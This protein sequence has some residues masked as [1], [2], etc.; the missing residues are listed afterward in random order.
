M[1]IIKCVKKQS[2]FFRSRAHVGGRDA[3]GVHRRVC[4]DRGG[5]RDT[6]GRVRHR[7]PPGPG[8]R[9]LRRVRVQTPD[10]SRD[11]PNLKCQ[12]NPVRHPPSHRTYLSP[13]GGARSIPRWPSR[14]A[15]TSCTSGPSPANPA[16]FPSTPGPSRT[17]YN[18]SG[19]NN[20]EKTTARNR[21]AWTE[22]TARCRTAARPDLT[23]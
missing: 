14:T 8:H 21:G 6:S 11:L 18:R 1:S 9:P 7:S 19:K 22:P 12:P 2:S 10:P 5:V 17:N 20:A 13:P 4:I 16:A 23:S 15:A 3:C